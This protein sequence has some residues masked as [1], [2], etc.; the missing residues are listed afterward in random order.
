MVKKLCFASLVCLIAGS[1]M[2]A[3]A[4]LD[5][6]YGV[7]KAVL[8]VAPGQTNIPGQAIKV[9]CNPRVDG[10]CSPAP[11]PAPSCDPRF[12]PNC[13]PVTAPAPCDPRFD[14][15]CGTLP[16]VVIPTPPVLIPEPI[17]TSAGYVGRSIDDAI[18][19]CSA[20]STPWNAKQC[21]NSGVSCNRGVYPNRMCVA[22]AGFQFDNSQSVGIPGNSVQEAIDN[23]DRLTS[24]Q[25]KDCAARVTCT[26]IG[27]VCYANGVAGDDRYSAA[28]NCDKFTSMSRSDCFASAYCTPAQ[29]WQ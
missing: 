16:P 2:K 20:P 9:G 24:I 18:R 25:R 17:C 5:D 13:G 3:S 19:A 14:N 21:A 12:D 11:V 26:G 1:A 27:D 8:K 23:C 15:T 10:P 6:Q 29:P 28:D 4:E 7:A 22:G